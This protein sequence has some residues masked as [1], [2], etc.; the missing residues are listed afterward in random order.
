M[1]IDD[2]VLA[3]IMALIV[4]GSVFASAEILRPRVTEPFTA[5]GLLNSDLKIGDYPKTIIVGENVTL[6]IF[7][8]NHM[9]YPIYYKVIFKVGD[10]TTLPTP[11][12]PSPLKPLKYW[13]GFLDHGEN[14]TFLIT[15][16]VNKPGVKKALIFELWIYDPEK[17]EW[18]YSGRWN[19]LYVDVVEAPV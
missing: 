13:E 9:G 6:G 18:M 16:S 8:D 12:S 19:H 4:V 2:E 10:N 14:A 15:I 11:D 3:V 5:I 17:G 7:V 1:I